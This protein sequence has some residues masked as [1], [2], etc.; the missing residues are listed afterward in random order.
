MSNQVPSSTS[1]R[2]VA[3]IELRIGACSTST[4]TTKSLPP[5]TQTA[6]QHERIV[7]E[8]SSRRQGKRDGRRL[9]NDLSYNPVMGVVISCASLRG[10]KHEKK[11]VPCGLSRPGVECCTDIYSS[12]SPPG[13]PDGS[14]TTQRGTDRCLACWTLAQAFDAGNGGR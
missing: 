4:Q 10:G 3:Q 2:N 13:T 5:P 12:T 8:L 9:K 14:G 1:G 11:L 7:P 6:Q